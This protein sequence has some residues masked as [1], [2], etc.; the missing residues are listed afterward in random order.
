MKKFNNA[1]KEDILKL[2]AE[3]NSLEEKAMKKQKAE[4]FF[5]KKR[6]LN[7]FKKNKGVNGGGKK[8][9]KNFL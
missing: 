6:L 1:S 7:R 3:V 2:E 5:K 4:A 9:K 8:I